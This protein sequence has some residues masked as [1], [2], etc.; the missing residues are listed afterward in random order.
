MSADR[1]NV[2]V[3]GHPDADL[4]EHLRVDGMPGTMA[5]GFDVRAVV[6][7]SELAQLLVD[8][9]P[10]AILTVGAGRTFPVLEAQ[11]LD[12]RR[13][14]V[15][16]DVDE[17]DPAEMARTALGVFVD[18]ATNDRFPLLPLVSVFTPTYNTGDR[19]ERAFQSLL[20]QTYTNWEWVIYDDS[21]DDETWQRLCAIRA[22]DARVHIFR[23]DRTCGR[24]GE[25]KRR[26]CGL[27]RGSVLVELDHDDE[28]TPQCLADVVAA[29]D[30]HPEAGFAYTDCA[31]VFESGRNASYGESFSFGF[32]TYRTEHLRGRDYL[33]TNYP[34]LNA[35]TIRHIVGVPNHVR[36]WRRSAY[37]TAG[38]HS[39]EV[40][41]ADDYELLVRTFLTTR[42]VHVHT[43]GYIQ[44]LDDEQGNTQ[45][46][47]NGEIQRAVHLFA[48]RYEDQIHERLLELGS[49][50]FIR[51]PSGND[52][53]IEPPPDLVNAELHWP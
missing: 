1:V 6:D 42:M 9:M 34:S 8:E 35:K 32:G 10:H 51:T 2:L 31:E 39:P 25:V 30:A 47:R 15:H 49:P 22:R 13:R 38:G 44:Y 4:A 21:P 26:A 40:H 53:S 20:A 12:V 14:W 24:I 43:F 27:A 5:D 18:V 37:V 17:P 29:F 45:R 48:E 52:W 11:P 28:L 19:I 50:D 7:D 3:I 41:V 16:V 23:S 46:R 33:V 36:A